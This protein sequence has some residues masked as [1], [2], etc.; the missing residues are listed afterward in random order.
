MPRFVRH[1]AM[2]LAIGLGFVVPSLAG[3]TVTPAQ[4]EKADV[5]V[6][7]GAT[8]SDADRASLQAS[9]DH[10]KDKTFPVKYVVTTAP[11]R[12]GQLTEDAQ[13]LRGA[14]MTTLGENAIDGVIVIAPEKIGVNSDNF[15]AERDQAIEAERAAI[16]ADS[17]DGAIRVA[18]R[19]QHFDEIAALNVT[20][21]S[22][23]K[24]VATWVWVV[25]GLVLALGAV[26]MLLARRAAKRGEARRAAASS[27]DPPPD[28]Q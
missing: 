23:K 9:A 1:A 2:V 8:L 10:L 28:P 12:A 22:V 6:D 25:G 13:R 27:A 16:Q 5:V 7:S 15:T 19:L 24:G 26:A 20:D 14:L 3:A 11:T 4:L 18:D 21:K 17:V